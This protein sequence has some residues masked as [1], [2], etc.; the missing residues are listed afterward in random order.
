MGAVAA[1]VG[2]VVVL[3]LVGWAGWVAWCVGRGGWGWVCSSG[4]GVWGWICEVCGKGEEGSKEKMRRDSV[5]EKRVLPRGF[6]NF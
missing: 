5:L 6:M 2:A 4:R 3:G 1:A